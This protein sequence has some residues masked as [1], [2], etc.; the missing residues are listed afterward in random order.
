MNQVQVALWRRLAAAVYDS[1]ILI[2]L[3]FVASLVAVLINEGE[4]VESPIFFWALLFIA[5]A[6]FVK[7]WCSPGQTLG[8]QVW[9]VKVVNERGGPL[10]PK[11]AS[12]RMIFA[13]LSWA[14]LGL[15]FIWSLFDKE[16]LTLH[17]KLSHSRL[18]FIDHKKSK[19]E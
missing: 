15:G 3:Y 11:Q 7:F 4:A 16:G 19:K 13:I 1:I 18:I 8:M 9:K 2:A 6:F 12:A 17:D 14:L 10:T 5:W